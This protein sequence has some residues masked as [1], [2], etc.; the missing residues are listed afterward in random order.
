MNLLSLLAQRGLIQEKEIP[1][2][3]EE[4]SKNESLVETVLL[5]RGISLDSE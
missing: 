3:E 5:K 1:S 2:I 4:A